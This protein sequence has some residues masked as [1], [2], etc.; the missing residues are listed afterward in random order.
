VY[1][2]AKA[3]SFALHEEDG[4]VTTVGAAS[5]GATASITLSRTLRTTWL[6]V[7]ADTVPSSAKVDGQSVPVVASR[8]A[9]DA[10]TSGWFYEAETRSAWVKVPVGPGARKIEVL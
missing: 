10:A 7:R 3:S 4:A 5:V 9:L 6:R 8:A 2:D 1:P